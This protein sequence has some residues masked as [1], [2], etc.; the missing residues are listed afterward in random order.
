LPRLTLQS[1]KALEQ[2]KTLDY[3]EELRLRK[4]NPIWAYGIVFYEKKAVIQSEKLSS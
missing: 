1:Q 3:A 2:I 4:T